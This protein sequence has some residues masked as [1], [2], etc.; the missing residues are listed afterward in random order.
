MPD[1]I[2]KTGPL[3]ILMAVMILGCE[4]KTE[5][6]LHSQSKVILESP[7]AK[8]AEAQ[9]T[10]ANTGDLAVP[11]QDEA[12]ALTPAQQKE[13]SAI[14]ILHNQKGPGKISI[15]IVRQLRP[16]ST[17]EAF[18]SAKI[19]ERPRNANEKFDRILIAVSIQD[20][21][22]RIETSKEVSA[23]LPDDF[24]KT[25]ISEQIAPSFKAKNYF[26]GLKA[27]VAAIITKLNR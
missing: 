6:G 18:A 21:K 27:G 25:V 19:N 24:C 9:D 4:R 7:Q 5:Q 17:I 2:L 20:R 10:T 23:A 14:L 1:D 15:C 16:E 11:V 12:M 22:M 13:L 26:E 8:G 3:A